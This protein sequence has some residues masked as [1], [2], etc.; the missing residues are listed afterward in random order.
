MNYRNRTL[1]ETRSAICALPF[2]LIN[3]S[4]AVAFLKQDY[5]KV[6][7]FPFGFGNQF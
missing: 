1:R 2:G 3:L 5:D 4:Y 6:E 7:H